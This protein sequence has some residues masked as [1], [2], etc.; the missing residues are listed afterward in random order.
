MPHYYVSIPGLDHKVWKYAGYVHPLNE[1]HHRKAYEKYGVTG[2]PGE[3]P[4]PFKVL[5]FDEYKADRI[6]E[7]GKPYGEQLY[8]PK[9][10]IL[11]QRKEG[12]VWRIMWTRRSNPKGEKLAQVYAEEEGWM[13]HVFQVDDDAAWDQ[14]LKQHEEI[15]AQSTE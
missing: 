11:T 2:S 15:E 4:G 8:H 3:E 5:T 12:R 6:T 14:A 7:D 1:D 10:I 13:R 9:Q